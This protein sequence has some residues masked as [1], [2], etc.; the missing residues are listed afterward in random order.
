MSG[1]LDTE[2][3][4]RLPLVPVG[5]GKHADRTGQGRSLAWHPGPYQQVLVGRQRP[6]GGGN[7]EPLGQLVDTGKPVEI[8]VTELVP[9]ECQRIHPTR[10]GHIHGELAERILDRHLIAEMGGKRGRQLVRAAHR[11]RASSDS[12]A[13]FSWSLSIPWSS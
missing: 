13:I 6:Q 1:E 2:H 10:R 9:R 4:E 7:G 11:Y 12:F 5:A 8:S 3:L